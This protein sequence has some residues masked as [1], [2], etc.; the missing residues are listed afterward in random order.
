MSADL[1]SLVRK[2]ANDRCEYCLLPQNAAIFLTFHLEHIRALQ[3]QGSDEPDNRALACPDCN[4]TKGP[5][6]AS[7]DTQS[8]QL[9]PLF[10]PRLQV[11]TEHF[12]LRGALILGRTPIGR[13]TARLLDMNNPRRILVRQALQASGDY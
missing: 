7:Y 4:A 13:A 8:D 1:R 9:V 3:H 10:N 6:V 5:N 12:E 11:W 2:R